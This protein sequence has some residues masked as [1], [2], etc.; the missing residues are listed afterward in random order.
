MT[1][2]LQELM[3]QNTDVHTSVLP[4]SEAENVLIDGSSLIEEYECPV[5]FH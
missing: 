1:S 2:F 5:E 4:Q 3:D